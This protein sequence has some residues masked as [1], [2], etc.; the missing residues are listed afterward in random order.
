MVCVCCGSSGQDRVVCTQCLD[1]LQDRLYRVRGLEEDLEISL[2]RAA[3]MGAVDTGVNS[4]SAE[5]PLPFAWSAA[6]GLA[7]L[8]L[9][10]QTWCRE[11]AQHRGVPLVLAPAPE[12]R[13]PKDWSIPLP[14]RAPAAM[15]A[16]WMAERVGWIGTLS[17]S[18]QLMDEINNA[19]DVCWRVIDK[20]PDLHFCGP[21][22]EPITNESG[23]PD[24]CEQELYSRPG[25]HSI[26]CASCGA[27][28]PA[29]ERRQWLL[30]VV[31]DQLVTATE[32]SRALPD[33]LDRP[34]TPSMIRGFA[35]RGRIGQHP[36]VRE[37]GAPLYQVG[38]VLDAVIAAGTER[39]SRKKKI[40][41]PVSP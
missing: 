6:E 21:C 30:T 2:C 9:T 29:E 19:L 13:N 22:W 37:G 33:L 31:R 26:V 3:R 12:A 14:R 41:E 32:A 36:P 40:A 8:T 11:L 34:I 4:P 20:A 35:H 25:A 24:A 1:D 38:A 23:E 18:P 15:H 10:L 7:V 28:W 27:E 5:T 17:G 16:A 39:A